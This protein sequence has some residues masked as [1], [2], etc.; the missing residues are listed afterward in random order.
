MTKPFKGI[1][2]MDIH[3][4]TPDWASYEGSP[5]RR[6]IAVVGALIASRAIPATKFDTSQQVVE[7]VASNPAL[8]SLL[9]RS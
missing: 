8:Y 4:S 3:D 7:A 5:R 9:E 6:R 2:N 1:V